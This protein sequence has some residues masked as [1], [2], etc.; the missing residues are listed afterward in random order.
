MVGYIYMTTNLLNNKRYIGRKTSKVFLSTDYLGSGVHLKRAIN[1]YGKE[2][3][4]VDLIE[5]CATYDELVEREM[6]W[7][8][9]YNAVQSPSF[10]NASAGGYQEGF[11]PGEDN[12]AKKPE[13][14]ALNSA[15]HKGKK[16][17]LEFKERQREIHLGKPS[18]MLGKKHSEQFKAEQAERTRQR[19]LT[20]DSSVY[21]KVSK[22]A[23]GNK[24]MNKD[25]K[26]IR[27]HPEFFEEYLQ[28]GWTFGGLSRLGKYKNRRRSFKKMVPMN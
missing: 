15:K 5:E 22:T 14:R 12:I 3:F 26:C 24:M 2:N 28:N 25:G 27:V 20:R 7:I 13:I 1:K 19:N 16:M 9:Y 6:Y 8:A 10:Y 23:I 17:S 4:K 18:G 11:T 21:Q